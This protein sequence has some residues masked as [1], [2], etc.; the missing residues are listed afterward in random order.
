MDWKQS[1]LGAVVGAIL[2]GLPLFVFME[3]RIE[4]RVRQEVKV[5]ET[6]AKQDAEADARKV[7]EGRVWT[8]EQD[9]KVLQL[10]HARG[11]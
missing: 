9:V 1:G 11:E 2:T 8:V 3:S 5:A 6:A 10:E 4:K 7:L